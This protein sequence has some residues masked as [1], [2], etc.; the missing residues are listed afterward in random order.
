MALKTVQQTGG[1][2]DFTDVK[3]AIDDHRS[4]AVAN[5]QIQILDSAVYVVAYNDIGFEFDLEIF[6]SAGQKPT[7]AAITVLSG[8][9]GLINIHGDKSNNTKFIGNG[10]IIIDKCYNNHII[11]DVEFNTGFRAKII[12]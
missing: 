2:P 9:N 1:S 3:A 6:I 5:G 12:Y 11:A 10:D 7:L 4:N 8:G